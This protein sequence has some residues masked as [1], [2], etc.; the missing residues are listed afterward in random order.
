MGTGPNGNGAGAPIHALGGGM[1]SAWYERIGLVDGPRGK[2]GSMPATS[3]APRILTLAAAIALASAL[4][5]AGPAPAGTPAH[6]PAAARAPFARVQLWRN[7]DCGG[8]S[9]IVAAG[10]RSPQR[11]DFARF[12]NWDGTTHDVDNTRSSLA[13]APR[14]CVRLFDGRRYTGAASTLICATT[15][16]PP[17]TGTSRVSTTAPPP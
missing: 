13:L 17:C 1:A 9:M 3:R 5:A 7:A 8:G 2:K 15:G 10:D 4:L 6:C 14:T 12:T 11:P 16:T